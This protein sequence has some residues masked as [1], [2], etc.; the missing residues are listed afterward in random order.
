ML[1]TMRLTLVP[2]QAAHAALL[3]EGLRD[4]SLYDFIG[5]EPPDSVESLRARYERLAGGKSPDGTEAWLNW[6]VWVLQES[7]YVGYVQ[8][9]VKPGNV[10]EIAYVLFRAAWGKGY[11][12][13]AVTAMTTHLRNR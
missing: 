2:L 5:D 4:E 12:R 8:A 9:T 11:A 10:A 7:R 3:F 13:E 1:E 6:A